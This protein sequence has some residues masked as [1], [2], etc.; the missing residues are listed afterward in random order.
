MHHSVPEAEKAP[1]IGLLRIS[2]A[3]GLPEVL[4]EFGVETEQVLA[5]A[6][7]GPDLFSD[8][9]NP[10]TYPQLERLFL[11]CER[12][13]G[14]D[15]F[16]F[17]VGQRS[18]LADMGLA[19]DVALCQRTAG[20]GL[21]A[22][23]E[24]FNLHDTAATVTL[25]ESGN[26]VRFVYAISEHGMMDTRHFQQGGITIAWNILQDLCGPAWLPIGVTFA[27]RSPT[28]GRNLQK[29]FRAPVQ[30]DADE[31]AVLFAR[32]WLD[33]PLPAA[34]PWKQRAVEQQVSEQR[35]RMLAD[36]PATLRRMLRKQLLLGR[37]SMDEIATHLSMHRRT[38]DRHL[39]QNGVQYGELVESLR[40]DIARQLLLDT[41]MPIQRIAETVRFS[42]AA[43]F[44]TAFRRRSGMTPSEFRRRNGRVIRR[45]ES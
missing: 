34:H 10:V 22:F 21:T 27:T 26:Y 23:I 18:R 13:S 8:R 7:L 42:S 6:A 37:F 24:H 3:W 2:A 11:A 45:A 32:H 28:H 5:D 31:S 9:E 35:A 40:E 41:A 25:I 19:G 4:A 15:H 44:A 1:V 14:C 16:G 30:F 36:F 12:R 39:Q 33:E 17:L 29:Y 43:N 38:L 20:A